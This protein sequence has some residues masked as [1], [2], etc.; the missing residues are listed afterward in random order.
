MVFKKIVSSCPT[1][2]Q[3]PRFATAR[4]LQSQSRFHC[5]YCNFL[6][7]PRVSRCHKNTIFSWGFCA[8][9]VCILP[10]MSRST[11]LKICGFEPP[12]VACKQKN[13]CHH[14]FL[15]QPYYIAASQ[16]RLI[17][18]LSAPLGALKGIECVWKL[19]SCWGTMYVYI[20][21]TILA[22]FQA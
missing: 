8:T 14:Y 19:A 16:A 5:L 9:K 20:V 22:S 10:S 15:F 17:K 2:T 6:F 13:I 11:M 3:N 18:N 1:L 7:S 21:D 4:H 12:S